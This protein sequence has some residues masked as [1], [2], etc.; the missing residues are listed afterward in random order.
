LARTRC[1]CGLDDVGHRGVVGI[2]FALKA[3]QP[4]GDRGASVGM[5]LALGLIKIVESLCS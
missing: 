3:A 5:N 2:E 4:A 1:G